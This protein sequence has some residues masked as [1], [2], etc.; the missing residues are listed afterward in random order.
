MSVIWFTDVQYF[1]IFIWNKSHFNYNLVLK[2]GRIYFAGPRKFISVWMNAH[3]FELIKFA[4]RSSSKVA[5]LIFAS[6]SCNIFIKLTT[7]FELLI[8]FLGKIISQGLA[9]GVWGLRDMDVK[10][11][12]KGG[13]RGVSLL[14]IDKHHMVNIDHSE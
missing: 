11:F 14:T 10:C 1:D 12:R 3:V 6:N 2:L 9:A 8:I 5:I 4:Y 13:F 7:L